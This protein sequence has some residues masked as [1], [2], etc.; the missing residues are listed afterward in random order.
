M[1][2]RSA[3]IRFWNPLKIE[4]QL[5]T[6]VKLISS[7]GGLS[8]TQFESRNNTVEKFV[9][10]STIRTTVTAPKKVRVIESYFLKTKAYSVSE[11]NS[12]QLAGFV[13]RRQLLRQ[14]LVSARIDV[15]YYLESHEHSELHEVKTFLA[16]EWNMVVRSSNYLEYTRRTFIFSVH[17]R[18]MCSCHRETQYYIVGLGV[19][20]HTIH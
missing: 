5:V 19:E 9:A 11:K 16:K 6:K 17:Y 4:Y 15:V 13:R 20:E 10:V 2:P 12:K 1:A 18:Y 7:T 14:I 8:A 3:Q